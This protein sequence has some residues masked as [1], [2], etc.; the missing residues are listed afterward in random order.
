VPAACPKSNAPGIPRD[1]LVPMPPPT[2]L[3]ARPPS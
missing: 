2:M 3:M 1:T